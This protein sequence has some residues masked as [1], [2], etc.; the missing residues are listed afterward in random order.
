M[1]NSKTSNLANQADCALFF[2]D[3]L[4]D[5]KLDK[6]LPLDLVGYALSIIRLSNKRKSLSLNISN[7]YL[8]KMWGV[9][10]PTVSRKL[11]L[12]QDHRIILRITSGGEKSCDGSF[13]RTRII[14]VRP[15]E[16]RAHN[17]KAYPADVI[18]N[19]IT[20]NKTSNVMLHKNTNLKDW[21]RTLQDER[22]KKN[23]TNF[24]SVRNLKEIS[25]TKKRNP[26]K[27][28]KSLQITFLKQALEKINEME[29]LDYRFMCL[30]LR[31]VLGAEGGSIA[32]YGTK[33][34]L[35][36]RHKPELVVCSIEGLMSSMDTIRCPIGW[37][38]SE[39]Q[40]VSGFRD[41]GIP[42]DEEKKLDQAKPKISKEGKRF[43]ERMEE[44]TGFCESVKVEM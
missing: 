25:P 5:E 2:Y 36:V 18:S 6:T 9:S 7:T 12:L 1:N 30:L 23:S 38:M 35:M 21:D 31:Q 14:F 16:R 27:K 20:T 17:P 29:K 42:K 4:P 26:N 33:L 44:T 43:M 3:D 11:K 32:H 34:H 39:L 40:S 37:F 28:I 41:L 19:H 10:V 8:S 24:I 22:K 13:Y 15:V